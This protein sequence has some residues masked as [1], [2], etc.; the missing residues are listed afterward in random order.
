MRPIRPQM[1]ALKNAK[2]AGCRR[3]LAVLTARGVLPDGEPL[4]SWVAVSFDILL[5][6]RKTAADREK[7]SAPRRSDQ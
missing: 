3:E 1:I 5:W 6:R 7:A 2:R 4:K